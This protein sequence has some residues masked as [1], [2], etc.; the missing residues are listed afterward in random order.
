VKVYAATNALQDPHHVEARP[1]LIARARSADLVIATGAELEVGWLPLVIQ[2]AGNPKIRPWQP[3]YFE[4]TAFV[5][6]LDLK[7]HQIDKTLNVTIKSF[8]LAMQGVAAHMGEG[9]AV[10]MVSGVDSMQ[11]M[12]FHG[13]LGACKGAL[14]V[15]VKYFAVDLASKRIR[16]NG[17]NPGFV[18]TASSR[19]YMGPAFEQLA[20]GV[21]E[22]LPAGH[23]ASADEIAAVAEWLCTP[24]AGYVTGQTIVVDGGL[25]VSYLMSFA[26]SLA[27]R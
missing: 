25:A 4:A 14:E 10:V 15:L 8:I 22:T 1:S 20:N 9:G 23:V 17:I 11:P 13:L 26:A 16:V 6:L 5:P 3:G 27:R 24:E 18:D 12:P 2:Q 21:K 19:F 7:A